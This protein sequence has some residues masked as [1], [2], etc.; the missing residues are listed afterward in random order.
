MEVEADHDAGDREAL[1]QDPAH[2]VLGRQRRERRVE[3]HHDRAVEPGPGEQT[4]LG[5]LVAQ[6]K[7]RLVRPEDRARM[8]LEGERRRA[9]ARARGRAPARR[10]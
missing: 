1:D 10:R 9:V 6:A 2:E 3:P 7:H 5:G 8:R 4:Q